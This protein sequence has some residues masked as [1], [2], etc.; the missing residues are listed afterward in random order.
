MIAIVDYG[1]GNLQSVQNAFEKVGARLALARDAEALA[2]ADKIVLPGVGHFRAIMRALDALAVREVI[3]ER[4]VNGVPFLGVC[5]GFQAL[6]EGSAESPECAG[7]GIFSGQ[8]ERFSPAARVPHMGWNRLARMGASQLCAEEEY[9]YFAHSF[10][11]PVRKE[12]V[13]SCQY[14]Q[15]FSAAVER[16]NC[17]GVQ[18]HP[19]KSGAAGLEIIRRFAEL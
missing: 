7:L 16:G 19:E 6:Y 3:R 15:P 9:V 13:M 11:V 4:I 5:L 12:T 17:F 18:F 14:S 2:R 10:Y 1:A 8:V